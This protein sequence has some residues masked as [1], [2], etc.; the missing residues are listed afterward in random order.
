MYLSFDI[1][2]REGDKVLVSLSS[3]YSYIHDVL[4]ADIPDFDIVEV[5]I[6]RECGSSPVRYK[7]LASEHWSDI[8]VVLQSD[9]PKLEMYAHF[10][11]RDR[12]LPLVEILRKEVR[13]N[14]EAISNQK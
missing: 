4:P 2:T 9:T 14:F 12:H 1:N 10:L 6:I 3:S 7:A 11:L 8:E 5:S 13:S